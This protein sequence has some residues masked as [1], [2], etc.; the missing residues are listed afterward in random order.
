MLAEARRSPQDW[1]Q[2]LEDFVSDQD[3]IACVKEKDPRL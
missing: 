3:I 2:F 1:I